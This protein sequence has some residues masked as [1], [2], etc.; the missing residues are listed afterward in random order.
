MGGLLA[1]IL[2][3]LLNNLLVVIGQ[4]FWFVLLHLV[5]TWDVMRTVYLSAIYIRDC[6]QSWMAI[7]IKLGGL[8]KP[9]F[10]TIC[11]RGCGPQII[12]S[13]VNV[14]LVCLWPHMS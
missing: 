14:V 5:K 8:S 4:L 9:R 3:L 12:W 7:L 1:V 2:G 6:L 13:C 10:L 11:E